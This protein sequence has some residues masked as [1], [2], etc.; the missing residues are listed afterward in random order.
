[1]IDCDSPNE[2][3]YS[4]LMMVSMLQDGNYQFSLPVPKFK[5]TETE[6]DGATGGD[7]AVAPMPGVVEKL[8]VKLGDTVR[9][10]DPL[11]IIIAMKMEVCSLLYC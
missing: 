10:G 5:C 7:V 11:L 9:A 8:C 6:G 2:V 1:L 3:L 4:L